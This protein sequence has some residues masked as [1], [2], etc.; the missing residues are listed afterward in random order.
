[1]RIEDEEV[2]RGLPCQWVEAILRSTPR[3]GK[4]TVPP[5][6]NVNAVITCPHQTGIAKPVPKQMQVLVGGAPALRITDM[7][8]TPILPGCTQLPT[9]GTP[10]FVPCATIVA[11]AAAGSTK[12]MIGGVPALLATSTMT[13]NG[14]PVP[15]PVTVKFPGQVQV[16]A[17]G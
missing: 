1:M 2:Q 15:T 14:V 11:P 9:P 17:N 4:G 6:C 12:V 3:Q 7:A 8:G 13:S 5:I 10:G 16:N